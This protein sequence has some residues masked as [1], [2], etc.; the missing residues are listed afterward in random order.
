VTERTRYLAPPDNAVLTQ[1]ELAA[2]FQVSGR[3]LDRIK[4]VPCVE[5]GGPRSKRYLVKAV[6]AWLERQSGN[7]RAA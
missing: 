3:Q 4:D 1:D 5:L 2:W 6:I 7:G